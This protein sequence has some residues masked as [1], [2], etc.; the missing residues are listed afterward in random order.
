MGHDLLKEV[1]VLLAISVITITVFGRF[2]IPSIIG[3][4]IVGIVAGPHA[5]GW[6]HISDTTRLLG[7]IGVVFLL[8]TIGLDFSI[9]QLRAMRKPL[10]GLGGL[11]V[12]VGTLSGGVIAWS[13]G[14]SWE[15]ALI[16]GGALALSST[17]IV[18]KQLSEQLEL[19]TE[20]GRLSFSILLFQDLAAV[21]F[22]VLIPI[23]SRG[24]ISVGIL[25]FTL[26]KGL[27]ALVII[28]MFGRLALR[29]IFHEIAVTRS[30]E[31]F[32][33]TALLVSLAAAW[34]THKMGLSLAL[35]AFLAGMM[36]SETE[37]RHQIEI[38]IRP[39]RDILLGLFFIVVG[40]QL[41]ISQF[42]DTWLWVVLLLTGVMAGKGFVIY[43]LLRLFG[44][45]SISSLRA[46]L[47]LGQGGEFGIALLILAVISNLLAPEDTQPILMAVILSM[48]LSP[49]FIRFNN[50]LA[51]AV[52]RQGVIKTRE[53]S[54]RQIE[55]YSREVSDHVVICGF[56]RVGETVAVALYQQGT[57]FIGLDNNP[58]I[59]KSAWREGDPVYFGDV[60]HVKILEAVG[61]N[62][63]KA[64][65]ICLDN[66]NSTLKTLVS[67]RSISEDIIILVRTRDDS[68][69]DKLLDAGAD[70]VIT[71]KLETG[72]M[73]TTEL[74]LLLKKSP[75]EVYEYV[76]K[77]RSE[78]YPLLKKIIS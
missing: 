66:A 59:I 52:F 17:A 1:L 9:E 32:T 50:Q 58:E 78:H 37:F 29:A 20:P 56:G 51:S 42:T 72:I 49:I 63:A 13:L 53:E 70:E 57:R 31:L 64:L 44:Y 67:A 61:L 35:G 47:I 3:Y 69:V 55:K 71:E 43:L 14:I 12:L 24:E 46:G 75:E 21:P 11:Q 65:V 74:L 41:D 48:V 19:Q 2:R 6:I 15:G 45:N 60:T 26:L 22:L 62:R 54:Y 77:L 36:L 39:F 5:L 40:M 27:L 30:L 18:V 10:F 33:L 23:L 76:K 8:F 28:L 73:M 7:E 68:S 38:E 25:L 4:L 16:V 34:F